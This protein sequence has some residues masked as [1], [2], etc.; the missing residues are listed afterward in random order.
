[1]A[2][3][4]TQIDLGPFL[5]AIVEQAGG[6]VKIAYDVFKNQVGDKAIAIDIE[7]DGATLVLSIVE[8]IPGE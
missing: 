2:D 8:D 7:D 6:Q 4:P 1:M 5:A 3:E